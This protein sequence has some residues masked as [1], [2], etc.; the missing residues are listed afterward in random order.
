MS[1]NIKYLEDDFVSRYIDQGKEFYQKFKGSNFCLQYS[2]NSPILNA[3]NIGRSTIRLIDLIMITKVIYGRETS[4]RETSLLPTC[5]D[6]YGPKTS[7]PQKLTKLL[8]I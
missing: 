1:D 5:D 3:D 2:R 6:I 7:L 8:N 4:F